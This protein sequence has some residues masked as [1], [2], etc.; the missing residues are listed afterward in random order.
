MSFWGGGWTGYVEGVPSDDGAW[1]HGMTEDE[2]LSFV[3]PRDLGPGV[4][5]DLVA[6]RDT[7]ED[8]PQ[9]SRYIDRLRARLPGRWPWRA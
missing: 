7:T 5:R 2:F 9:R 8:R 3:P 6:T 4:P 1:T